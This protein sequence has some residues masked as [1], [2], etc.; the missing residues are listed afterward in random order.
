[1]QKHHSFHCLF[2]SWTSGERRIQKPASPTLHYM[3]LNFLFFF[4][5]NK[6]RTQIQNWFLRIEWLK[7]SIL[8]KHTSMPSSDLATVHRKGFQCRIFPNSDTEHSASRINP[9]QLYHA[10]CA[11]PDHPYRLYRYK[12]YSK[13]TSNVNSVQ[14]SSRKPNSILLS[15]A[16]SSAEIWLWIFMDVNDVEEGRTHLHFQIPGRLLQG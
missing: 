9:S 16:K 6:E 2:P 15:S 14:M 12:Q 1:M 7:Y 4:P 3:N 13:D 8:L 10:L 5:K 11:F